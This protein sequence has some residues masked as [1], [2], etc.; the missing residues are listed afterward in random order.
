M[1]PDAAPLLG[2]VPGVA[3]LLDGGR[4]VAQWVRR[5]GRIGRTV[6]EWITAGETELDVQSYR[7]SRFG[8]HY[9]DPAVSRPSSP[10][11]RTSTTTCCGI[12]STATSGAGPGGESP[13]HS[14]LQ[15]LGCVFGVKNA[16]ERADYFDP[17]SRGAAPG[18]ISA[19]SAG[20]SHPY[21]ARW[22]RSTRLF[23]A[24]S[25]SST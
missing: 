14:R 20:R 23:A 10:A 1:T 2:P 7:P 6:A 22:R 8:P 4:T 18:P 24:P 25:G 15:D 3:R 12:R 11:R 5:R 13:L 19:R 9:G 17:G 21:F 16:W